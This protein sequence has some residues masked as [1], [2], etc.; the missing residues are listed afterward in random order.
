MRMHSSAHQAA[1]VCGFFR[2]LLGTSNNSQAV[3]ATIS[4][5]PW[6]AEGA[7]TAGGRPGCP[8]SPHPGASAADAQSGEGAEPV[9]QPAHGCA[10]G[11]GL[12]GGSVC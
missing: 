6:Q 4:T 1:V 12:H 3:Y 7:F 5:I 9:H 2:L 10:G 8:A 11:R